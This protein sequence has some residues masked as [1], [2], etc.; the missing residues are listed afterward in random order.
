[1]VLRLDVF[2]VIY[3]GW[4][5]MSGGPPPPPIFILEGEQ[6]TLIHISITILRYFIFTMIVS[7]SRPRSF[8]YILEYV[9]LF[10]GD[11]VDGECE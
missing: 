6:R 1:M 8:P 11:N 4:V 10:L 9:Q 3:S 7:L 5:S 2:K